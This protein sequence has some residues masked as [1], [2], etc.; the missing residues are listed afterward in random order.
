MGLWDKVAQHRAEKDEKPAGKPQVVFRDSGS[1]QRTRSG[2]IKWG[3][4]ATAN[5]NRIVAQK[6]EMAKKLRKDNPDSVLGDKK[7]K[8]IRKNGKSVGFT[9][10]D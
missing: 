9:R 4:D 1:A 5:F 2:R 8:Y 10:E 7:Y 6:K 3:S